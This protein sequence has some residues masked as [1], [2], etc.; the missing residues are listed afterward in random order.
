MNNKLTTRFTKLQTESDFLGFKEIIVNLS[1]EMEREE[2]GEDRD[3]QI[4]SIIQTLSDMGIATL[5]DSEV[6]DLSKFL[7][8][9]KVKGLFITPEFVNFFN[10][11]SRGNL[12]MLIKEAI[13]KSK[14]NERT[15][16]LSDPHYRSNARMKITLQSQSNIR[17]LNDYLNKF[18][19]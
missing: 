7:R 6:E 9:E 16:A 10:F 2:K 19:H 11:V 5:E 15:I 14:E 4:E 12:V 17:V 8:P 3:E 1:T 13:R 18:N